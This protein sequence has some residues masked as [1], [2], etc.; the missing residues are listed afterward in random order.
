MREFARQL[1]TGDLAACYGML[2][3]CLR[4]MEVVEACL[5]DAFGNP[6]TKPASP[7]IITP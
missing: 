3:H 6:L 1:E 4:V 7:A 2:E 5:P